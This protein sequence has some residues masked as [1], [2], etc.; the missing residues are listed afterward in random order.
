MRLLVATVLAALLLVP[1]LAEARIV[2]QEGMKGVR[3]GMT[4]AEVEAKLGEPSRSEVFDH[5][6]LGRARELRYGLTTM[7]FSGTED[8]S[9]MSS[10]STTSRTERLANGIGIGSTRRDVDRKVRRTRCTMDLG[11]DHCTIGE[12]LPGRVVTDF[13]ISAK[14]RV[15]RIVVGRVID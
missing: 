3:L 12:F 4:V 13:H 6:I 11:F 14:G 5:P 15:K 1:S 7:S 10:V 8:D 2:P 9:P